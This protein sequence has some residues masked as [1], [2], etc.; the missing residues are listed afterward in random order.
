M[1]AVRRVEE[2]EWIIVRCRSLEAV[3]VALK[4]ADDEPGH[5]QRVAVL[6]LRILVETFYQSAWRLIVL[7][8]H[9]GEP[10]V[11]MRGL[12]DLCPGVLTVR[13]KLLEHPEGKDSRVFIQSF[14]YGYPEGPKVKSMRATGLA[15]TIDSASPALELAESEK[16]LW[17]DRGLY[18]NAAELVDALRSKSPEAAGTLRSF[19]P[20]IR[21]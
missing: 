8:D 19:P 15:T 6:E 3:A 4:S 13:N 5:Q 1:E 21:A 14:S 7:L 10:V 20:R 12:R 17:T 11:G 16:H 9:R 18:I 2:L